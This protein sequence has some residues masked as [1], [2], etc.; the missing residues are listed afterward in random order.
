MLHGEQHNYCSTA[1]PNL[2]HFKK[3][4]GTPTSI[5]RHITLNRSL[6][7]YQLK[8][9][10]CIAYDYEEI[11]KQVVEVLPRTK[12]ISHHQ[13]VTARMH[14]HEQMRESQVMYGGRG[15]SPR[16]PQSLQKPPPRRRRRRRGLLCAVKN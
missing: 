14:A 2:L 5:V 12:V 7:K 10:F 9:F 6:T 1:Q 3:R 11:S 13:L 8:T 15:S 16:A 4:R